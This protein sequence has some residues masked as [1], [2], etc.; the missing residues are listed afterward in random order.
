MP[1]ERQDICLGISPRERKE[2][3]LTSQKHRSEI[4]RWKVQR[5]EGP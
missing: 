2:V 1:V 3:K 5:M 4:L